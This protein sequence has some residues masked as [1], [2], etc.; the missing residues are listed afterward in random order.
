MIAYSSQKVLLLCFFFIVTGNV[1]S[2]F[3]QTYDFRSYTVSDGLPH[4]QITSMHQSHDGYMW[5]GTIATGLSRFDGTDFKNYGIAEGLRDDMITIAFED[6]QKNLWVGTYSGGISKLY[7]DTLVYQFT[8]HPVNSSYVIG[9]FESP[10]GGLWFTTFDNGVFVYNGSYLEQMNNQDGLIYDAVWDIFWDETGAIW[11]A[12]HD[13]LSIYKDD[14]FTN[15]STENG[16][17]GSKVF[18]I[19]ES[20]NGTKWLATNRG[21]TIFDG[22]EISTITEIN[23]K[24]L[25]YVF[26]MLKATDGRIWIG[27]ENDG[28]YWYDNGVFSHVKKEKGLVSNYIQKIYED[29]NGNVWVGTD[30]KGISIYR[31][32]R[33]VFHTTDTGLA[34]NE[35]LSIFNDRLNSNIMWIGTDRGLQSHQDNTYKE[36]PFPVFADQNH[37]WDITQKRNGSLLLLL[38]DSTIWLYDGDNSRNYIPTLGANDLYMHS[39]FV[40]SKDILWIGADN[41]LHRYDGN[42]LRRFGLQDGIRGEIIYHIYETTDST[43][44]VATNNGAAYAVGDRFESITYEDGLGHYSVNYIGEDQFGEIWFGTSAG[45]TH[46]VPATEMN[47]AQFRNFGKKDGMKLV[48]TNYLWF[49]EY[50][51]LWQ[52]TNGGF[53]LLDVASYRSTGVLNIEH[54][55]ISRYGI[56]IE[57]IHKSIATDKQN[58]AYFG[59]M[60]G[61]VI[62][63]PKKVSF[64]YHTT[65]TTH[66]ENIFLNGIEVDWTQF[67]TST[68]QVSSRQIFPFVRFPHGKN[69]LTF[70]FKGIDFLSSENLQYRYQMRGFDESW[71][72]R[73]NRNSATYTGLSAGNYELLV[74][75]RVGVGPWSTEAAVYRFA[76]AY[77]FWQTIWFWGLVLV[78][79]IFAMTSIIK[80]RVNRIEL[81]KLEKLVDEQT[82]YLTRVIKE[83]ETLLKEVHHRVKNN[84]AIIYGMLEMQMEYV[85]DAKVQAAFKDSQMRVYSI[86]LVHEKL[87]QSENISQVEAKT[88]IPELAESIVNSM[89]L[90]NQQVQQHLDIDDINLTLDQGIP[91]GLIMN[92]LITNAYKHAFNGSGIGNVFIDLKR[93]DNHVVLRIKD[94]GKGLPEEFVIGSTES[95][96]LILVNGL[97]TQIRA[98]MEVVSDSNGTMFQITFSPDSV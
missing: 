79:L 42:E 68:E 2:L 88:Y 56:G 71:I 50:D 51:Q 13:G 57:T 40:D 18:R 38:D 35:I 93:M 17:S 96:G 3:A 5:I 52:G 43:L 64:Q 92:E 8:D 94:D 6:S 75:S 29:N 31:G 14:A 37:I 69:T 41:G 15:Y 72:T 76:V 91:C 28:I 98:E 26:D 53:H 63:D 4:G 67:K 24:Q 66:I 95:L 21:I 60:A 1:S 86:S 33:F 20:D 44:W 97:I 73:D 16:L 32:E 62:L 59:T 82:S 10:H 19:V 65:P 47:P 30:E 77:P 80:Y 49:D 81:G 74:Q 89:A 23:G 85:P 84:L 22:G 7:G 70:T 61:I 55:A 25:N 36:H 12:T 58:R 34:S 11:F 83:K 39:I 90:E 9:I 87:Y 46:Y 45:V 54:Y 27:M 78:I 48:E